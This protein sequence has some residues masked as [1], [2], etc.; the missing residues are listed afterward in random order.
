MATTDQLMTADE[1]WR[2]PDDGQRREL[3]AGVLRTMAPSSWV[4]GRVT[5]KF[6]WPL[7]QYV[8]AHDLGTVF[9]AETGC[10]LTRAPDTVR[11]ADIAFVTRERALAVAEE[12]VFWP[13]APALVAEVVS[14]NDR[15]ADVAEKVATWLRYGARMVVVADPRARTLALHRPDRPVHVLT[16]ADTLDGEDVVPGWRLPVRALFT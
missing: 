3:V 4:H 1:L 6:A 9:G 5:M 13:G 16:E 14:P 2:L 11:A 7:A 12:V 15:P 8:D 10:L